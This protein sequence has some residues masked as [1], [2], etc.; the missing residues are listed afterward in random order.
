MNLREKF[1]EI[2]LKRDFNHFNSKAEA[3]Q[4][5]I[6]AAEQRKKYYEIRADEIINSSRR[7][8]HGDEERKFGFSES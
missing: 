6:E 2:I 3:L 4:R 7:L 1:E 8:R 5:K